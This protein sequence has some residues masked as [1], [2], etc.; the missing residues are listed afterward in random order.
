MD[1]VV[2]QIGGLN[3]AVALAI[4][5][6]VAWRVGIWIGRR[7]QSKG[8]A[9]APSKFDDATFALFGLLLAFTFG[10]SISKHDQRRLAVVA[11]SNAIGDFYTCAT[12]L[13]EP[14]RKKLQ[15]VIREYAELL[16]QLARRQP[17]YEEFE[18]VLVRFPQMHSQMT[19]LVGQALNDGTPIAVPLTNTLNNVTSNHAARLAALRDRLPVTIVVLLFVSAIVTTMLIGRQQGVSGATELIGTLC[20]ILLVCLAIYVTLDLNQPGRGFIVVSQEPFE[21]LLSSMMK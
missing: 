11:D 4:G 17:T 10:M 2:A 9:A 15:G 16:L 20:F 8:R 6:L 18:S 3:V 5:M 19:D 1:L 13:K 21:K 7:I 14:T 12:L